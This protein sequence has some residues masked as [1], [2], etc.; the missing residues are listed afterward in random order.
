MATMTPLKPS[1]LDKLIGDLSRVRSDGSR[2]LLPCFV[3]RLDRFNED[4]L[5]ACVRRDIEWLL[6]VVHFEAAVGLEDYPDVATSVLN[7]GLPE[8]IGR[9]I[10]RQALAHRGAEI[11]AA[12]RAFEPRLIASSVEVL[13]DEGEVGFENRLRFVIHGHLMNSIDDGFIALYTAI[14]LDTGNVEINA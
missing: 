9:A 3:P 12:V 2:D 11:V 6:N 13:L 10:D 7:H 8:L 1:I 14:D 4:E 5:R